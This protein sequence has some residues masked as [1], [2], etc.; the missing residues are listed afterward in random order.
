METMPLGYSKINGRPFGMC[1]VA[2]AGNE[3]KILRAMRAWDAIMDK[4]KAP[5]QMR[6]RCFLKCGAHASQPRYVSLGGDG[7]ID[8]KLGDNHPRSVL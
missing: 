3:D 8:A 4:R 2:A 5:P 7:M 1:I 6:S